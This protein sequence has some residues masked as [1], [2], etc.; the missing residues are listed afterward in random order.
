MTAEDVLKSVAQ[1]TAVHLGALL[2]SF[3]KVVIK[4]GQ[5]VE[6]RLLEAEHI[7]GICKNPTADDIDISE[8]ETQYPRNDGFYEQIKNKLA[9]AHCCTQAASNSTGGA[10]TWSETTD[11]IK[12]DPENNEEAKNTN[13]AVYMW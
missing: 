4:P 7:G 10:I 9:I 13:F 12:P 5:Q 8:I 11:W 1:Q 6:C 2:K 3:P